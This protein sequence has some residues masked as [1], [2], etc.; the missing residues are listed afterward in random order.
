MRPVSQG[1]KGKLDAQAGAGGE[2]GAGPRHQSSWAFAVLR[3]VRSLPEATQLLSTH[4][5]LMAFAVLNLC[6]ASYYLSE[7]APAPS[8]SQPCRETGCRGGSYG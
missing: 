5:W 1:P 6:R 8:L 2:G 7:A 3:D 4:P